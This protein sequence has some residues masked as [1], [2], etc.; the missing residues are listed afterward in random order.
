V[1]T[2]LFDREKDP[3][4]TQNRFDDPEYAEIREQLEKRLQRWMKE[5]KDP[6]DW[7][8]R[9]ETKHMLKIGQVFADDKWNE[10]TPIL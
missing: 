10:V 4:E 3:L 2:R 7:G 9:D 6:F 8:E 1:E 5:T